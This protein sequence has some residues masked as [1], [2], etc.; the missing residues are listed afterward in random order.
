[1]FK[2]VEK[3]Q[4]FGVLKDYSSDEAECPDFQERNL[5][6]GWNYSGKTTLSRIFRSFEKGE[7]H[8]DFTEGS[9]QVR[10]SS[11]RRVTEKD[12][13]SLPFPVHVFNS[14]Y[15]TNVLLWEDGVEPIFILGEQ[16][17]LLVNTLNRIKELITRI[18]A[19]IEQIRMRKG[20]I[21]DRLDQAGTDAARLIRE[22][23]G[24]TPFTR[25]H[26]GDMAADIRGGHQQ[27]ILNEAEVT[28]EHQ[29]LSS[30]KRE[31]LT[32]YQSCDSL[33]SLF[34]EV[35]DVLSATAKQEVLDR[36]RKDPKVE[37]W[38]EQGLSLH[39]TSKK[40]LFCNR[41]LPEKI[42]NELTKHFSEQ[43]RSLHDTTQDYIA[44]LEEAKISYGFPD[45]SRIY[46]DLRD[47]YEER[48]GEC[49]SLIE[50]DE[51]IID[52]LVEEL[53]TKLDNL[54]KPMSLSGQIRDLD[55]DTLNL[56][57]QSLN[58]IIAEHN[59]RC[60]DIDSVREKAEEQLV[61]HETATYIKNQEYFIR[62][63]YIEDLEKR[64]G[65]WT[66]RIN[67]LETKKRDVESKISDEIRGAET[68]NTYL[69]QFFG[70]R[71]L[72]VV[73]EDDKYFL[74][75][76]EARAKNLSEGEKSAIAFSY[77]LASLYDHETDLSEAVVYIDDPVS[78]L[79]DNHIFNTFAI[80]KRL[81]VECKQVFVSTHNYQFFRLLKSD[82]AFREYIYKKDRKTKRSSWYLLRRKDSDESELVDV[83]NILRKY[84]SEY[85]YLFTL[86]LLFKN[87]F[88]KYHHLIG[89]MPN[90]LRKVLETYTSFRVP[91]TSM[92]L[93]HRLKKVIP[94]D[95]VA[96]Q[97]IYKFVNHRSHSD[98]MAYGLE[99]PQ[100]D[101]CLQVVTE[102]LDRLAEHDPDHYEGMVGL[103]DEN[104]I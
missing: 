56:R 32:E 4:D 62:V 94:N 72:Q 11:G 44:A 19:Y 77:F 63:D 97:K 76:E 31:P 41:D 7:L 78:S 64:A 60:E 85:H 67:A 17:R 24:R 99:F 37:R 39:E 14:D 21:E 33:K 26:L 86:I 29:K 5:I 74:E 100:S 101:E 42:L 1:M 55:R 10:L 8:T 68:I 45:K 88:K 61:R 36:L 16:S 66:R 25:K 79:D 104:A 9:F 23:I 46:M 82:S 13:D 71:R 49:I 102:F 93:L 50:A 51:S 84:N 73:F 48:V 69:N 35:Q 80:V 18:E 53:K 58:E 103:V 40:C 98:S 83:P 3:I 43:W 57:I 38:V 12:L 95:E 89:S 34:R 65:K 59:R 47:E 81:I 6:Y 27:F 54:S 96:V 90:M 15:V 70:N 52:D 2:S 30:E 87:D 75:R 22:K 91:K 92:N 20:D 28:S